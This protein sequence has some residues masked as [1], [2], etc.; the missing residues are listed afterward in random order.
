QNSATRKQFFAS[1][2]SPSTPA[3]TR[4]KYRWYGGDEIGDGHWNAAT[5]QWSLKT[6]D[7][8]PVFPPTQSHT[9]SYS[10]RYRPGSGTL[11][12]KDSEG[13]PLK[14]TLEILFGANSS[15]PNVEAEQGSPNWQLVSGGWRLLSDRVGIELTV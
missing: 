11:I 1:S 6:L 8:S 2:F 9:K 15:E 7:L 10:T 14:A 13:R 5:E 3:T 12:A 4:R